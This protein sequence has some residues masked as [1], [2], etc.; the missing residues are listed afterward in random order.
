M[1]IVAIPASEGAGEWAIEKVAQAVV[2][3]LVTKGLDALKERIL[4][5]I[6]SELLNHVL[7]SRLD[8][9]GS[10]SR[11]QAS[12][13]LGIPLGPTEWISA[14]QIADARVLAEIGNS[15]IEKGPASML[16]GQRVV[17]GALDVGGEK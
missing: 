6:T 13:D 2:S 3:Y 10:I 14:L 7:P 5:S 16:I 12:R 1:A 11:T 9:V 4:G 17:A 8:A 15:G